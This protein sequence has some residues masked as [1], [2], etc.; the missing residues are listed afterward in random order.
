MKTN[1]AKPSEI[2]DPKLCLCI[3]IFGERIVHAS[4]E[5]IAELEEIRQFCEEI[6]EIWLKVA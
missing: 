1:V 2:V 3:D 6:K 4:K 5:Y